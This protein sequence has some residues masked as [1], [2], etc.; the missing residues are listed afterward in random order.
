MLLWLHNESLI[1][2]HKHPPFLFPE[3]CSSLS[4]RCIEKPGGWTDSDNISWQSHV[5]RKQRMLQSLMSLW[6]A[7][8]AQISSTLLSRDWTLARSILGSGGRCARLQSLNR[9]PLRLQSRCLGS[10]SGNRSMFWV[11]VQTEDLLRESRIPGHNVGKLTSLF[12]RNVGKL[13]IECAA[14]FYFQIYSA[15][16]HLA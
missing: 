2:T 4:T 8:L 13:T 10:A 16:Q 12:R 1:M 7:T 15:S 14:L 6:K 9:R 11:V 3:R 5:S